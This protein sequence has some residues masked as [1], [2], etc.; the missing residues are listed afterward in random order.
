VTSS[1]PVE[2]V[3][4][5]AGA[6]EEARDHGIAECYWHVAEGDYRWMFCRREDQ[7]DVA[8]MW[9][10]GVITGWQHVFRAN[11]SV[12]WLVKIAVGSRDEFAAAK[13][14]IDA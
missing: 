3:V 10:A 8:V 4:D 11:C 5:F 9:C 14:R 2:A 6:V 13:G 12:A 7:F 1:S